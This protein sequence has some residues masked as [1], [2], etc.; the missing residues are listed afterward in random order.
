MKTKEDIEG[1]LI[2]LELPFEEV[3]DGL[4]V[5]HDDI[6]HVDNIVVLYDPPIVVFRV[7]LMEVPTQRRE[8]FFELLLRFNAT[9]MIHGAYGIEN[10]NV[11]IIDT[12]QAENLDFNEF[13]AS[14]EAL[15]LAIAQDYDTLA[16]FRSPT[17]S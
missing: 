15:S 9:H 7:K 1:Y 10:G 14:V 12:L 4:W 16:A 17:T 3:E 13:Q 5:I 2:R 8:E 11:V 6:S